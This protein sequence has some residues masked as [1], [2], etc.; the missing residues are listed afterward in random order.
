MK[1]TQ[2][3]FFIIFGVVYLGCK[4]G[5]YDDLSG[6]TSLTIVNAVVGSNN[7]VT[8]FNGP[9]SSKVPDSLQYY[10]TATQ[11]GYG[12]TVEFSGYVGLTALSLAPITDTS[13]SLWSG[14]LN[15]VNNTIN[16]LFLVGP[17]SLHI[18]T[19]LTVDNPIPH[20]VA[21]S[22]MGIR[23]VNL[24]PGS[25]PVSVDLAGNAPGSI[26]SNLS[27][28]GLT[29]FADYP[30]NAQAPSSYTF[31]FRDAT[32]GN[33]LATYR[34]TQLLNGANGSTRTNNY[35][36]RNFTICLYGLPNGQSAMLV[37]NY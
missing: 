31:E 26:A 14:T 2:F 16:S 33:V 21:D 32:S 4:K 9:P 5:S 37:D 23:F 29:S 11:I 30:I 24:S 25:N 34:I 18:D 6:G 13:V 12:G 3:I 19:L 20:P 35:R 17:D 8:N 7:L 36:Y 27:Y 10:A 15:I 1:L 22:N 28:K